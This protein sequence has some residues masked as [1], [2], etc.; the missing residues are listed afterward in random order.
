MVSLIDEWTQGFKLVL[1]FFRVLGT[2]IP[3]KSNSGTREKKSNTEIPIWFRH[4]VSKRYLSLFFKKVS[5]I[6]AMAFSKKIRLGQSPH[7]F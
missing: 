1:L 3:T 7:A 5:P 6:K 2:F 4:C